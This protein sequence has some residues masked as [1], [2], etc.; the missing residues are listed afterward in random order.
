MTGSQ[1]EDLT[2]D[3][4]HYTRERVAKWDADHNRLVQVHREDTFALRLRYFDNVIKELY[5]GNVITSR[6]NLLTPVWCSLDSFAS[7]CLLQEDTWAEHASLHGSP[8]RRRWFEKGGAGPR[9]AQ[10]RVHDNYY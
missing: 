5:A 8:P 4:R 2:E 10:P 6:D 7:S 1:F 9:I 3:W